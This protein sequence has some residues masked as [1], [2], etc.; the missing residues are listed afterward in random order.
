MLIGASL[1]LSGAAYQSLFKD[2][3]VSPGV[4]GVTNGA[5]FGAALGILLGLSSVFIQGLAFI[6]GTLFL[7][8]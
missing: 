6:F 7:T 2:P 8:L 4:L 1:S 5:G 3:L